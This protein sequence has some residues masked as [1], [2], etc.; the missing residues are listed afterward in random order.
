MNKGPAIDLAN[1]LGDPC[2]SDT[3]FDADVSA[4]LAG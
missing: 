3:E 1:N 4:I 2:A